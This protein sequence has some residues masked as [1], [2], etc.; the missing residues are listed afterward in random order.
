MPKVHVAALAKEIGMAV[1]Y[2]AQVVLLITTGEFTTTVV[3][4]ARQLAET[5]SI[6]AI[7]IDKVGLATYIK[8]GAPGLFGL[9]EQRAREI[10]G[11]KAPQRGMRGEE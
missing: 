3:R 4:D 7:L 6:Q 5:S 8:D 9:F 11:W 10:L 1:I 2:R